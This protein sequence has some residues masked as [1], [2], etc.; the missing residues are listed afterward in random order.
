MSGTIVGEVSRPIGTCVENREVHCVMP[1]EKNA[2]TTAEWCRVQED[3][4][5]TSTTAWRR[6][7]FTSPSH[8]RRL[9]RGRRIF[10]AIEG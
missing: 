10:G 6:E 7:R 5:G 2:D 3:L 9:V 4:Q 8:A 1:E